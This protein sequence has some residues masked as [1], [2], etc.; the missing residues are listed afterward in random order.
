MQSKYKKRIPL[1][2]RSKILI[3]LTHLIY[4]IYI[5]KNICHVQTH[6]HNSIINYLWL[7]I[8]LYHNFLKISLLV[9]LETDS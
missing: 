6:I 5:H 7:F 4:F 1:L 3:F 9:Y 2:F 8:Y